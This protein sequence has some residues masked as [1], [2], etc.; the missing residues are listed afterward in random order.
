MP[1]AKDYI[2]NQ[3]PRKCDLCDYH[4]NNPSMFYYHKKTHQEIPYGQLCDH[5][6]NK[7][8][9]IIRTN[10]SFC[11]STK[12]QD[13]PQYRKEHSKRV[14]EQWNKMD[15]KVKKK[16]IQ[17][18][19]ES[20]KV[21]YTQEYIEKAKQ[22]KI[23]RLLNISREQTNDYKQYVR[24]V[25]QLTQYSIKNDPILSRTVVSRWKKDS[26]HIDHKVSK[27]I[28]FYLGIP[29]EFIANSLNLEAILASKNNQKYI[30][31]SMNPIDLLENLNAPKEVID[32]AKLK[33][34]DIQHFIMEQT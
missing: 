4:S 20:L 27:R 29:P 9:I 19:K 5:G 10:G 22:T 13:C 26:L 3:Y 30:K 14:K 32:N 24:L 25:H 1:P 15:G 11:C 18:A 33:I 8:A 17:K 28:G 23:K 31:C 21:T 16:R 12:T 34:S 2:K 6:C 7:P